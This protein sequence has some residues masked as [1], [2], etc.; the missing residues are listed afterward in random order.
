[1]ELPFLHLVSSR[2]TRSEELLKTAADITKKHPPFQKK[3]P[4]RKADYILTSLRSLHR[5]IYSYATGT[6]PI[7]QAGLQAERDAY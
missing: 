1:M 5:D 3:S 2:Y 7:F 4:R 6:A